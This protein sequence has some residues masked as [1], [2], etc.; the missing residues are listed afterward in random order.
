MRYLL[1]CLRGAVPFILLTRCGTFY[2]A[3]TVWYLYL[4]HV[5][6]YLIYQYQQLFIANFV[7][8][9]IDGFILTITNQQ[10][11]ISAIGNVYIFFN[12]FLPTSVKKERKKNIFCFGKH[13]SPSI[14]LNRSSL[15]GGRK[16]SVQTVKS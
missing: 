15:E 8:D 5:V 11:F 16:I 10:F 14:H 2:L 1:S 13:F 12:K 7:F 9:L 4:A 6:R 3:Q